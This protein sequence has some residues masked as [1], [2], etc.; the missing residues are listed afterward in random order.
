MYLKK[1]SMIVLI[2]I[3][4]KFDPNIFLVTQRITLAQ[5]QL[6][7]AQSCR[8]YVTYEKHIVKSASCFKYK[9]Y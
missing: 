8:S 7:V 6:Q 3:S 9:R 2:V 5:T 4:Y 1:T